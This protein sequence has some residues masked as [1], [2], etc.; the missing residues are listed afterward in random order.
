MCQLP[1]PAPAFPTP[2]KSAPQ[3]GRGCRNPSGVLLRASTPG[4][5]CCHQHQLLPAPKPSPEERSGAERSHPV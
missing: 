4:Q 1:P 3:R 5:S 2:T